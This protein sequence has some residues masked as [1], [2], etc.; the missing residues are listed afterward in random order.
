MFVFGQLKDEVKHSFSMGLESSMQ[1]E[2]LE[3]VMYLIKI[4]EIIY[5]QMKDS[6]NV[7]FLFCL[8]INAYVLALWDDICKFYSLTFPFQVNKQIAFSI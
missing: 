5:Y 6:I 3:I 2:D 7:S 8:P 1:L 4:K